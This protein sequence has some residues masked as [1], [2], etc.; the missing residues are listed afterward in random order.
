M[1]VALPRASL[2]AVRSVLPLLV[3]FGGLCSALAAPSL[4]VSVDRTEVVLG[5]R[6]SLTVTLLADTRGFGGP[7]IQEP[8]LDGF[9]TVGRMSFSSYDSRKRQNEFKLQ[10]QLSPIKAGELV[11]GPFRYKEA[12]GAVSSEP[13]TIKVTGGQQGGQ[14]N[15]GDPNA[16]AEQAPD[17]MA[18]LRWEVEPEGPLWLGQG[19]RARLCL[20]ANRQLSVRL[21]HITDVNPQGFW[22]QE[23]GRRE[24]A[25][26]VQIGNDVFAREV[27]WDQHLFPIR[28]G[29]LTLPAVTAKMV[30]STR[31]R[32][33][34]RSQRL[35][36]KV[37]AETLTVRPLPPQQRPAD[38]SGPAV[39]KVRLDAKANR[40]KVKAADGFQLT[41]TTRVDG[42][43]EN[44]PE[45]EL[46][47]LPGL[48]AFPPSATT[49]TSVRGDRVVGVRRQTWLIRPTK[50]G[51]IKVPSVNLPYFDPTRGAYASARTRPV[52]VNVTGTPVASKDADPA[53]A[54]AS[55]A[56]DGPALRTIRKAP[57][58]EASAS[59]PAY[60]HPLLWVAL[61]LPPLALLG[62]IVSER[63]QR[64][65]ASTAGSRAA[66]KAP[67]Q[68]KDALS[69]AGKAK[70][71]AA[72]TAIAH[73]LE[74]YF[75]AR[76]GRPFKGLTH[77]KLVATLTDLGVGADTAQAVV[78][79]LENCDFA[80]FAPGSGADDVSDAAGRAAALV[81]RIEQEVG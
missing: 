13:I 70:A 48:K 25:R 22:T 11:I 19:L 39:G 1:P 41:I 43:I 62:L 37:A 3:F 45:I 60:T 8:R 69:Q 28:V 56:P 80:R 18:F 30:L 34:R 46:P 51:R 42:L 5:D 6:I 77:P 76:F 9:A 35:N 67:R 79:E 12:G 55:A 44:V 20:Y 27:L 36:R 61:I 74:A 47:D 24:R 38:F 7:Q 2:R 4:D 50:T 49:N 75:E 63:L 64:N 29:E 59:G 23:R 71:S 17:N 53:A 54:A 57:V 58:L 14:G 68:A 31:G 21:E 78:R 52:W 65:R 40:T 81:D 10:L 72:Y 16:S 26:L 73:A 66:R 32:G 33:V 15:A